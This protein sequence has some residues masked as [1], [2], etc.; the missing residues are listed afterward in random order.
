MVEDANVIPAET[1]YEIPA[2]GILRELFRVLGVDPSV[3]L[4][5]HTPS[6]V[7]KVQL[8]DRSAAV[9]PQSPVDLGLGKAGTSQQQAKSRLARG[10]HS[11]ARL[12]QC[13]SQNAAPHVTE[14]FDLGDEIL[15]GGDGLSSAVADQ[16]ISRSDE[17]LDPPQ[18]ARLPPGSHRVLDRQTVRQNE[19]RRLAQLQAMADDPRGPWLPSGSVS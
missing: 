17:I 4:R 10:S 12:G 15:D 1:T 13:S 8:R 11:P 19:R 6:R 7:R 2:I 9:I 18:R 16:E 14:S 3:V 5:R